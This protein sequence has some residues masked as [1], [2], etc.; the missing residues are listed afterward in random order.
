V[1]STYEGT[2]QLVGHKNGTYKI[3]KTN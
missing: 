3:V 2:Q 1:K